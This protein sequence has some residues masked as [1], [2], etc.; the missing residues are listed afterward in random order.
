MSL[1][2]KM[3]NHSKLLVGILVVTMFGFAAESFI[4][5]LM[6]RNEMKNR[7]EKIIAQ[8]GKTPIPLQKYTN[9]VERVKYGFQAQYGFPMPDFFM[10]FYQ[11]KILNDLIDDI[12]Y[13]K[14]QDYGFRIGPNEMVDLIQGE[15]VHEEIKHYFRNPKTGEFDKEKL[16]NRMMEISQNPEQQAGWNQFEK[17]IAK[18]RIKEKVQN[19]FN[20]MAYLNTL[21]LKWEWDVAKT[22][23]DVKYLFFPYDVIKDEEVNIKEEQLKKYYKK[24]KKHFENKEEKNFVHYVVF[25]FE[26]S[27]DDLK[28]EDLSLGQLL[29]NFKNSNDPINFAESN[30]DGDSKHVLVKYKEEKEIPDE[31]K[32]MKVNE[33]KIVK[34]KK[35]LEKNK[36]YKYLGK[37]EKFE[38]IVLEQDKVFSDETKNDI[39][40]IAKETK[41]CKNIEQFDK[42][43]TDHNLK[44]KKTEVKSGDQFI[45]EF[46]KVRDFIHWIF[47]QKGN[48]CKNISKPFEVDKGLMV[49][50]VEK[51][52]K[53]GAK[54]FE[55]VREE[56]LKKVLMKEKYKLLKEKISS[57]NTNDLSTSFDGQ[58]ISGEVSNVNC[59]EQKLNDKVF[60]KYALFKTLGMEKGETSNLVDDEKGCFIFSLLDK[61]TEPILD[62]KGGRTDEFIKFSDEVKKNFLEE[63]KQINEKAFHSAENVKIFKDEVL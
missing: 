35:I 8:V 52:T 18:L 16:L 24:Y 26:Q 22:K 1:V 14:V 29:E 23:V 63:Y 6:Q 9:E 50:F 39:L 12:I 3:R 4:C 49:G 30:T 56:I 21:D 10:S 41:V 15:H 36:I 44:L 53:K 34:P 54:P 32:N 42:F 20:A 11:D 7:E 27:E 51:S 37:K 33:F 38:F 40:N 19:L 55:E 43:A 45:G 58:V 17:S 61:K 57:L 48:T 62:E 13:E 5:Y 2:S 60:V 59:M 46:S 47:F 28:E 25:K 31:I